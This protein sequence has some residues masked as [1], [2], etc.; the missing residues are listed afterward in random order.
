MNPITHALV[1]WAV[2]SAPRES[3][4]RDRALV[5]VAGIIPDF[6]GFGAPVEILTRDTTQ[7]LLWW[8]D[9][10]HLLGHN[11]VAGVAMAAVAFGL[12]TRRRLTA[13]LAFLSFH[14]HILGDV[15]G[16]RG[17]DGYD[18]PIPYLWPFTRDLELAWSGQWALNAWPNFVI[19]GI[20]LALTFRL[21]W[22]RGYSPLEMIS[23]RAD[24]AFV[25]TLRNRFGQP[26]LAPSP[27]AD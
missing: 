19:T 5:T 10:H 4:A 24:R 9:Y 22:Q 11:L 6:D 14:L 8:T 17:P 25:E 7:P 13:A 16:A 23:T 3:R 1:G 2:A 20:L 15:V 21:A 12:G 26:A 27:P 18:W